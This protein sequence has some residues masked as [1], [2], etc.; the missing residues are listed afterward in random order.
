MPRNLLVVILLNN[1][2]S[3]I[4]RSG[5]FY[6]TGGHE[7]ANLLGGSGFFCQICSRVPIIAVAGPTVLILF[8]FLPA[9]GPKVGPAAR[10][11][12]SR[13]RRTARTARM[14]PKLL[15]SMPL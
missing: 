5:I 7:A 10:A 1:D 4:G 2:I 14:R 8:D 9:R 13:R 12:R 15:A 11:T 6:V 3:K